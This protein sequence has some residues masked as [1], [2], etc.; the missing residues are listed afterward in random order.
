MSAARLS[1][2]RA[3][4]PALTGVRALAALWVLGYHAWIATGRPSLGGAGMGFPWRVDPLLAAGWMGVDVFFVLSGFVLQWQ[5]AHESDPAMLPWR[6]RAAYG[7]FLGRRV[8]RVF[9]AYL[10]CLSILLPLAWLG[11]GRWTP[12][13]LGD[14]AL[15]LVM[16][17]NAVPAY[18]STISGVFWSL[19]IEWHFYLVFPL[20]AWILSGGRAWPLVALALVVTWVVHRT[21]MGFPALDWLLAWTPFRAIEFA[22]GMASATLAARSRGLAPAKAEAIFLAGALAMLAIAYGVGS[23][24]LQWWTNDLRTFLRMIALS[25]AVAAMLYAMTVPGASRAGTAFFGN[26]ASVW[27]GMIS[28]SLYLWHLSVIEF[29]VDHRLV[30]LRGGT[31]PVDLASMLAVAVPASLAISAA[32]Y[33]AVERRFLDRTRWQARADVGASWMRKPVLVTAAWMVSLLAL[34]AVVALARRLAAG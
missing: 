13:T 27:I 34:A 14:T 6:G 20:G 21:V 18:V 33:Y 31:S 22:S 29:L 12:P 5:V 11:V 3:D 10:A 17:H 7:R 25:T 9:P 32:S 1:T 16:T 8:L 24:G 4:V 15:H 19:P 23:H 30:P 26:R 28:Y 2:R